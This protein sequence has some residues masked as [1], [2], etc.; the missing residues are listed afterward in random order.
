[1]PKILFTVNYQL[2]LSEL[3]KKYL[4]KRICWEI[5][6][7]IDEVGPLSEKNESAFIFTYRENNVKEIVKVRLDHVQYLPMAAD[8][9]KR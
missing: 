6:Y 7:M 1:M 8:N 4:L 2:G 5:D 3:C 9:E